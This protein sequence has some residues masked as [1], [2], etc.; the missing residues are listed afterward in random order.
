MSMAQTGQSALAR[1]KR[2]AIQPEPALAPSALEPTSA[3]SAP[4]PAITIPSG[5]SLGGF[6]I[7]RDELAP[8]DCAEDVVM[9]GAGAES[10]AAGSSVGGASAGSS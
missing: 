7:Q 2:S 8:C 4:A 3:D 5:H 10:A 9:A 6:A 1:R